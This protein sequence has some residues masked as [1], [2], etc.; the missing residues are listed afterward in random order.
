MREIDCYCYEQPEPL[1]GCLLALRHIVREVNPSIKES[2]KTD[3][4]YFYYKG[5]K[6]AYLWAKG[7]K[8]SLGI[9][10]DR[11]SYPKFRERNLTDE[12]KALLFKADADLPL[13]TLCNRIKERIE[14]YENLGKPPL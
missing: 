7:T 11:R 12:T 3:V 1:R 6:L 5:W 2:F 14:F 4:P 13:D 9:I 8:V 10:Y